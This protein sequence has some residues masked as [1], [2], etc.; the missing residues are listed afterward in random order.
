MLDKIKA[1][2]ELILKGEMRP[3]LIFPEASTT[4]NTCI[5]KYKRGAFFNLKPV[6]PV[7]LKFDGKY[8]NPAN[9]VMNIIPH[10]ALLACQAYSSLEVFELPVFAPNDYFME[11]C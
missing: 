8:F 5:V 1:R 11:K 10:I 2:Q 4:N 7:A 6:M 3:L 9:D